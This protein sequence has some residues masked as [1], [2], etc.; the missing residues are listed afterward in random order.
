MR[1]KEAIFQH[2]VTDV[3]DNSERLT[4]LKKNESFTYFFNLFYVYILQKRKQM[5]KEKMTSIIWPA[6]NKF[7]PFSLF[8]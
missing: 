5:I 3:K 4:Y 7:N 8:N 1:D 2:F 6:Q